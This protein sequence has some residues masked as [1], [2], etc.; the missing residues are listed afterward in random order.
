[1]YHF[2]N[3]PLVSPFTNRK[4][5]SYPGS[6]A[7]ITGN[8]TGDLNQACRCI[9]FTTAVMHVFNLSEYKYNTVTPAHDTRMGN[10]R[11]EGR[12]VCPWE[13]SALEPRHIAPRGSVK[14][15]LEESLDIW[16]NH[17]HESRIASWCSISHSLKERETPKTHRAHAHTHT[18]KSHLDAVDAVQ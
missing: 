5:L 7:N 13:L 2:L 10:F 8:T 12:E 17:V 4:R 15:T 6:G 3:V 11:Q 9:N 1:M 18:S 14:N 16:F